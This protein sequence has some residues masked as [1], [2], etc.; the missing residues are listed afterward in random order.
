MLKTLYKGAFVAAMG[1]A[2]SAGQAFG[3]DIATQD[4][5]GLAS[6]GTFVSDSFPVSTVG[7]QLTNSGAN[8]SGGAGIDF[9]SFYTDTRGNLGP[10]ATDLGSDSSDFIGVNSFAGSN[11][12][13][14]APDNTAVSSGSEHNFQFND[15]DGQID[16]IFEPVD[17]SGFTDVQFSLN[18]WIAS[19]AYEAD[20]VFKI[21][22]SDENTNSVTVQNWSEPQLEANTSADD[23][24]ANWGS[25]S[26]NVS[27][28]SLTGNLITA[29]VTVDNNSGS[30]NIF[31]DNVAFTGV[32]EP[33]SLALLAMGG[34]ALIRRR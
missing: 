30:E 28:S 6:N 22:L 20:D 32:P 17:I 4:F 8:N 18:Y 5:N 19:T 23:G 31:I 15:T 14:V 16:L 2:L 33:A 24:S 21:V 10:R 3:L 1:L 9:G 12:P 7:A 34:L 26:F 29:T 25:L 11:A 27:T 13:D